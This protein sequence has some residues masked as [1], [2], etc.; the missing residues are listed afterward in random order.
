MVHPDDIDVDG[1]MVRYVVVDRG[2]LLSGCVFRLR[3]LDSDD[4]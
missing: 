1:G 4:S 2:R 3:L